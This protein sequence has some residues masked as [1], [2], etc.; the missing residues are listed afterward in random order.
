[1]VVIALLLT[2]LP[3]IS[4][5]SFKVKTGINIATT[6]D[7]IT[8]P[9]NRVGFYIGVSSKIEL[10]KKFFFNPELIYSSKGHKSN[11]Q[12]STLTTTTR[13]NYINAP[14]LFGFQLD[15]RT[16]FVFGPEFGYLLAARFL[17]GNNN[18]LSLTE[19][20]PSKFDVALSLGIQHKVVYNLEI[21]IRYNYGFNTLYSTDATGQRYGDKKGANRTFQIGFLF[22]FIK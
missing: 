12:G 6:K 21:E 4:Q 22:N 7:L 2:S 8:F 18:N 15:K 10:R 17:V 9:K 3:S 19:R 20:Y 1:M 13:L 16:A 11:N 5:Y 14:L